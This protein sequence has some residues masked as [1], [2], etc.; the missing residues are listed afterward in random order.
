MPEIVPFDFD[1]N[2]VRTFVGEDGEPWFVAKDVAEVLGYENPS[3]SVRDHCKSMKIIKGTDLVPLGIEAPSPRGLGVIPE[4]DVYRLIM[5]SEMP[6]A[7]QFEE[8]VVGEVLPQIRKTGSYQAPGHQPQSQL[9]A[10]QAVANQVA[11]VVTCM[12]EQEKEQARQAEELEQVKERQRIT[13]G[14]LEDYEWGAEFFTITAYHKLFIGESISNSRANADGKHLR[15]IADNQ[16]IELGR[17]PH[18]VWGKV[19]SYPKA[20]LDAYY[21]GEFEH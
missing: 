3:R 19:N 6:E 7:E 16:G 14:K 17:E 11:S 20:M 15:Q 5:R 2:Q 21:R 1:G 9:E 13:E 12:V 10:L 18:P 4:R 8:W